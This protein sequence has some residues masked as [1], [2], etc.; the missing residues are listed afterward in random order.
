MGAQFFL[1]TS[2]QSSLHLSQGQTYFDK[3]CNFILSSMEKKVENPESS[4]KDAVVIDEGTAQ[5]NLINGKELVQLFQK[6]NVTRDQK[7]PVSNSNTSKTEAKSIIHRI[8]PSSRLKKKGKVNKKTRKIHLRPSKL[9]Q[10]ISGKTDSNNT[11]KGAESR[12]IDFSADCSRALDTIVK[13]NSSK[14][15]SEIDQEFEEKG[16]KGARNNKRKISCAQQARSEYLPSS[17]AV[18]LSIDILTDY[19]DEA[20]LFPKKMSYMAELM[21]T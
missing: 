10:A 9:T 8:H 19:L 14:D 12:F 6:M 7:V 16:S 17:E 15:A 13:E 1:I 3:D 11:S 21:Y 2:G 20:I 18:N 4:N 5:E